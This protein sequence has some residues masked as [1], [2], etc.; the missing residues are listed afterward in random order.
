MATPQGSAP[1]TGTMAEP[2]ERLPIG[3]S[4]RLDWFDEFLGGMTG[5]GIFLLGGSPGGRKSGLATQVVLEL[6]ARGVPTISV[7]TEESERR[8]AE[9]AVKLTSDWG[10]REAQ[11]AITLAKC[12]ARI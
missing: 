8:F 4:D 5:G 7:L 6:G 10:K 12:D 9:R 1:T 3:Q 2:H 11:Q